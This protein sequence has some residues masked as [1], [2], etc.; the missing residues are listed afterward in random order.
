MDSKQHI[1]I[2]G[3]LIGDRQPTYII[4]ELSANHHQSFDRAV[5]IIREAHRAGADAVKLQTYTADTLTLDSHQSHFKIQSGTVWDGRSFYELYQKASTPWEWHAELKSIANDLGMDLF[6]SPFDAT[7]VEFLETLDVPAYKIASFEI[8][9]VPLLRKVAATGRP[10]IV[11]TG[12]A[13]L[14]EIEQAVQTLQNNGCNEVALLKCTSAYPAPP[15]SMNLKTLPDLASRFNIP[16]GLS[17]HTLDHHSAI[18]SVALGGSIIEKHLT[19]SRTEEGP[20]SSFSLEPTE[21]AELVNA[22]R[23]TEKAMGDINYGPT[24]SDQN[25]LAFRRSLFAVQDIQPGEKFTHENV[26]SLRPGKGLAPVHLDKVLSAT[27]SQQIPRGTP[28]DW[29]HVA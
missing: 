1:Q 8:I 18:T 3:R 25:N 29:H 10:V 17:D 23:T 14:E 26:R 12:L 24:E 13:S 21:F 27:A 9:D 19:L 20:D 15:E 11:S 22:V 4:A 6:S 7:A 5:D 16:V 28:L 2:N